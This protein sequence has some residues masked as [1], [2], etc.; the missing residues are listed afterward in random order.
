MQTIDQFMKAGPRQELYDFHEYE[1]FIHSLERSKS[2]RV[3]HYLKYCFYNKMYVRVQ[4]P[5]PVGL[6]VTSR[7]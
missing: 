5:G 3:N 2:E 1:Y 4:Q 6:K 7:K